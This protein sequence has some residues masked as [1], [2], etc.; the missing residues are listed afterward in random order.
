MKLGNPDRGYTC[1]P[2]VCLNQYFTYHIVFQE[3][4]RKIQHLQKGT[5]FHHLIQCYFTCGK[6]TF[7][8]TQLES[9]SKFEWLIGSANAKLDT[10]WI[11]HLAR[12]V[13]NAEGE[14]DDFRILLSW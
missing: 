11:N 8:A 9:H 4:E 13:R 12:H 14:L 5:F 1:H 7:L 6:F 2:K 3:L 10:Y